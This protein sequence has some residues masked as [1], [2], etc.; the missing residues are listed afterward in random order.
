LPAQERKENKADYAA[1]SCLAN[2]IS[3]ES[4]FWF[5]TSRPDSG[6]SPEVLCETAIFFATRGYRIKSMSYGLGRSFASQ[7]AEYFA[8]PHFPT[9][10]HFLPFDLAAFSGRLAL[11]TGLLRL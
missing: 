11:I 5:R 10:D 6:T 3:T 9:S 2:A 1:T 7:S 4:P 8:V